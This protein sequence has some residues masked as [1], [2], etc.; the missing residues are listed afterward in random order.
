MGRAPSLPL[1]GGCACGAV[2]YEITGP[3][4]AVYAC[5]CTDCQTL[6]GSAFS[7]A[8]PVFRKDFA[9]TRGEPESWVRTAAS[10]NA[11]PQR[12]CT[13][14][15]VRLFTEPV[16]GPQTVTVRPGTLDD[17]GWVRPVAAFY[18]GSAQP[19][20]VFADD[21]LTYETQPADFMPVIAAWRAWV[22]RAS[23][24]PTSSSAQ[25]TG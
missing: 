24:N 9:I 16:F 10:G 8:M 15:G 13:T 6:T 21:V 4:L 14:C 25:P 2:R 12:I 18:M 17:T 7:L 3:P 22:E 20:T 1:T 11:I 5:C 19:W 23:L